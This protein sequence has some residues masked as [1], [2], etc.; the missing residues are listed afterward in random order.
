[1]ALAQLPVCVDGARAPRASLS[2]FEVFL[3][4]I[5]GA[6]VRKLASDASKAS[7]ELHMHGVH[8]V[9]HRDIFRRDPQVLHRAFES[10]FSRKACHIVLDFSVYALLAADEQHHRSGV[11][12]VKGVGQIS[13]EPL[14]TRILRKEVAEGEQTV[15]AVTVGDFTGIFRRVAWFPLP[16]L[17]VRV[18]VGV[19]LPEQ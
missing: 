14:D 10:S 5:H 12:V 9:V 1:M 11:G 8:G 13:L 19:F 15:A 6:E 17:A 2:T 3:D 16:P 4:P 7:I 18:V